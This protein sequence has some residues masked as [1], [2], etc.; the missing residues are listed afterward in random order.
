MKVEHIGAVITYALP[1]QSSRGIDRGIQKHPFN[2]VIAYSGAGKFP[3][4]HNFKFSMLNIKGPGD[5]RAFPS[6]KC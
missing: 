5:F 4:Q 6:Y 3:P 1:P 2:P